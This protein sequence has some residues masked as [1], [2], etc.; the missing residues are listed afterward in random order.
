MQQF[1]A[2]GLAMPSK[3]DWKEERSLI[4]PLAIGG[5]FPADTRQIRVR[6][7]AFR[8]PFFRKCVHKLKIW[9]RLFLTR[10]PLL[11]KRDPLLKRGVPLLLNRCYSTQIG[12][13]FLSFRDPLS[14]KRIP[15]FRRCDYI[16]EKRVPFFAKCVPLLGKRD[17]ILG[18]SDRTFITSERYLAI[19]VPLSE[20]RDPILGERD[21]TF[22]TSEQYFATGDPLLVKCDPYF[23]TC[24]P[25]SGKRTSVWQKRDIKISKR[26]HRESICV[27]RKRK[28]IPKKALFCVISSRKSLQASDPI[29]TQAQPKNDLRISQERPKVDPSLTQE[30]AKDDLSLTQPRPSLRTGYTQGSPNDDTTNTQETANSDTRNVRLVYRECTVSAR[31]VYRKGTKDS[32]NACTSCVGQQYSKS[33]RVVAAMTNK[34]M[35]FVLALIC[36][37][38]FDLSDAWAQSAESRTAEGQKNSY[39]SGSVLKNYLFSSLEGARVQWSEGGSFIFSDEYGKYILPKEWDRG[40]IE[41]SAFG[42]DTISKEL[43]DVGIADGRTQSLLSKNKSGIGALRLGDSI[44]DALWDLP[45]DI[46]NHES[47]RQRVSLREYAGNKLIVLDFWATWCS[48]CVKTLDKWNSILPQFQNDVAVIA[49]H[50]SRHTR[51]P[52]VVQAKGWKFPVIV[53]E[54]PP[55][56]N[57]YFFKVDQVG[58]VVFIK[59]GRFYAVPENKGTDTTLI[60]SIIGGADP[61]IK[62]DNTFMYN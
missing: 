22:I 9:G 6:F 25:V 20:K 49:I 60:Q 48:P 40:E 21:H 2:N 51:V 14:A 30:I 19:C 1:Y 35:P 54:N 11:E 39:R 23:A 5:T 27:P 61:Y 12:V 31:G 62:S 52:D 58:N 53:G 55:L 47:G 4:T 13:P 15:F 33:R 3:M 44:P 28:T 42:Y 32:L 45:L 7:S 16:L 34:S 18:R 26:V 38:L 8:K 57:A 24:V 17:S 46:V 50:M 37:M 43:T 36:F 59:D 10:V 56:I 41:I 29:T